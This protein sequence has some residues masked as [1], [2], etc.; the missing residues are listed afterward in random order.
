M[1]YKVI[2][3]FFDSMANNVKREIGDIVEYTDERAKQ[4]EGYIEELKA[5]PVT[6]KPKRAI[7]KK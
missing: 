7:K 5:D 4:L 3:A 6:I 1:K 2:V